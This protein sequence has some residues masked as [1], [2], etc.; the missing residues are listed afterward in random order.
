MGSPGTR[1]ALRL[2][3]AV[4]CA[5][6]AGCRDAPRD[7]DGVAPVAPG[8]PFVRAGATRDL[9]CDVERASRGATG[10][11]CSCDVVPRTGRCG[12][13]ALGHDRRRALLI[14]APAALELG[15]DGAGAQALRF[16]LGATAP[17]AGAVPVRVTAT[18]AEQRVVAAW[19][20]TVQPGRGWSDVALALPS[21][22]ARL[23]IAVDPGAAGGAQVALAMPRLVTPTTSAAP[24]PTNVVV[25][26]MD[27]LRA[28]HTSAYGYAR[29][30][31]PH[32]ARLARDGVR[33]DLAYSTAAR[34]RP[35]TASLLTGLQPGFHGAHS[36][37]ALA[38][39][40]ATLAER[41]H[42]GGWSTWAFVTN[43]HVF[44][45]GLN[46][47]QGF[48]RFQAVPGT[49]HL[50]H[51]RTE[52]VNEV[53]FPH[54]DALAD[55]PFLL[56]VHALDP[57]APYDPPPGFAGRF[58]D[59]AY[60]GPVRPDKTVTADLV[61]M[62]I[63]EQDLAHVVGLYDEDILYQ[64]AMFG[65]LLERLERLGVRDRTIVVVVS[66]H[67][68]EFLEHGAWAHGG[69]LFEEQTRVPLLMHVPG[70][71]GARGAHGR[72]AGA[73]PRRHADLARLVRARRRRRLPGPRP[74][75]AA[76]RGAAGGRRGAR[77]LLRGDHLHRGRG[78]QVA[79][80][81]QLE[82]HQAGR[83]QRPLR[84]HAAVR[85]RRRSRRDA[86][87]RPQGARAGCSTC[88]GSCSRSRARGRKPSGRR[89]APP[90]SSTSARGA[91]SRRSATS[92]PERR[93]R[94]RRTRSAARAGRFTAT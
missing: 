42:R 63:G 23:A 11:A 80:L 93:H 57:H 15:V 13:V 19:E 36:G 76:A 75:A 41:F 94:A 9:L 84:D 35:A 50:H 72:D 47:E 1:V 58:T 32:L 79:A 68:E 31:T 22:P 10:G 91:S 24:G 55:E 52:E 62:K 7:P 66:D 27:T 44:G 89:R 86:R 25:Y 56:Y 2:G 18:D 77:R 69:R 60:A 49:R 8:P 82:D 12:H 53:L 37:F 88:T 81:G 59:P 70:V 85:P 6:L 83:G 33:F 20:G 17:G 34:T 28:D 21:A 74:D 3:V 64:D 67:G 87:R 46:F 78:A 4:L 61:K 51:A 90:S 65:L 14:D 73:D 38:P 92:C 71:A 26:L 48:D 45:H 39:Q 16:S 54:L 29:D 40:V 43:G 5:V 30:T